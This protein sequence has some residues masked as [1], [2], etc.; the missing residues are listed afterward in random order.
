MTSTTLRSLNEPLERTSAGAKAA[1]LA[2]LTAAGLPITEGVVIPVGYPDGLLPSA[3]AEILKSCA[4][5]HGLIARSSAVAEDGTSASYAGLYTSRICLAHPTALLDAVRAVR[6]SVHNPAVAAYSRALGAEASP[7]QMAVLVQPVLRPA[8]AGVLAADIT[9]G[10]WRIEAVHGLAEPLVSGSRTGEIHTAGPDG[11]AAVRPTTQS[12]LL[13]PGTPQELTMPPG[14]WV[15]L[16]PGSATTAKVQTSGSGILHLY[17][18]GALSEGPVLADDLRARLL[19]VAAQAADVLGL[20]HIDIEWAITPDGQLHLVQ[21]RPLTVPLTDAAASAPLTDAQVLHGIPAAPGTGAGPSTFDADTAGRVLV[22]GALDP[23]A[24]AALLARPAAVVATT[25][26]PLSHT[27]IITRELGIPCVT[28]VTDALTAIAPGTLLE[29]D[30][31]AGTVRL[32]SAVPTQRTEPPRSLASVAVLTRALDTTAPTDGRAATILW[33][34]PDG[35]T[36]AGHEHPVGVLLPGDLPAPVTV[37]A[38]HRPLRLPGMGVLL[39]ASDA[40]PPP[41][42]IAVLDPEGEILYRRAVPHAAN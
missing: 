3:V 32:A 14:E 24:V 34:D 42:E 8:C 38:T 12:V 2:R 15:T 4:A 11:Q 13:L 41:A 33:Y 31:S 27:A 19:T 40:A 5:P 22:C 17:T 35:P 16:A 1:T 9:R 36:T 30:G 6:A 28:N 21:A 23:G 25:G 20:E 10:S 7:P 37:P 29:V 18:P 39:W 26:G